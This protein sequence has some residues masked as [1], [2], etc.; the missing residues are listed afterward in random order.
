MTETR[1]RPA[2]YP[3]A[4]TVRI[5][6]GDKPTRLQR[7]SQRRA[8]VDFV[9]DSSGRATLGEINEHFGFDVRPAV[10][11]LIRNGWLEEVAE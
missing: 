9:L 4:M 5:A 1:G 2:T 10:L 3:D 7:R 8:V 11:A 6:P